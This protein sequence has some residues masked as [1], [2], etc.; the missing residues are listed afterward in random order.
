[1]KKQLILSAAIIIVLLL[2]QSV[3]GQFKYGKIVNKEPGD[4]FF[5]DLMLYGK[6]DFNPKNVKEVMFKAPTME[7]PYYH[8][9]V[10]VKD[11]KGGNP[12][13]SGVKVNGEDPEFYYTFANGQLHVEN[14]LAQKA[15]EIKDIVL[16]L[17]YTWHNGRDYNINIELRAQKVFNPSGTDD[18][19]VSATDYNVKSPSKGGAPDKWKYTVMLKLAEEF[20]MDRESEPVEI[21]LCVSPEKVKDLEKEVRVME[22]NPK[23]FDFNE[24]P[25]QTYNY[26]EF[27][28]RFLKRGSTHA[29][30]KSCKVLFLADVPANSEKIYA[31]CYGNPHAKKPDYQTDL[32]IKG[33]GLGAVIE[34]KYWE[35]KLHDKSGQIHY[36]RMKQTEGREIPLYSNTT[37][38]SVH[39]NPDTYG[40]MGRWGHTFSWDPPENMYIPA[41]GPLMYKITR[42]GRMPGYNP[43]MMVAVTYTFI[44]GCPYV[45]MSSWMEVITPY[46]A[47]AIRNGEM[48]FDADLFD[49]YGW[50]AKNG[51]RRYLRTL[52]NP[53]E[54]FDAPAMIPIDTPWLCLYNSQGKYAMGAVQLNV[55]NYNKNDGVPAVYRPK[56]FLYCHPQ[57]QRPL[58]YFVRTLVYPFGY[59]HRYPPM[60]IPAGNVYIEKGAYFPFLLGDNDPFEPIEIMNDKLRHPLEIYYGN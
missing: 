2:T 24:I 47:S 48:V 21:E 13:I 35:V 28:G 34:N 16:V 43:E 4:K 29:P 19:I 53:D 26:Q 36:Y 31:V 20:G 38:G 7:I 1:M 45:L 25:S 30:S 18:N 49:H 58:T 37:S 15:D 59:N 54:G 6:I 55:Y 11:F 57:W 10:P 14:W 23:T 44:A 60:K 9:I 56:Y 41:K 52:L 8:I 22:Y 50:K 42:K 33:D 32:K 12:R 17:K 40:G 27:E 5:N 39:W 46:A 3:F 51:E